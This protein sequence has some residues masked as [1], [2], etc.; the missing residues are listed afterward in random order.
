[1]GDRV[2]LS[3]S[4]DRADLLAVTSTTD[5]WA[6]VCI[7]NTSNE[8]I[9]SFMAQGTQF[10]IYDD[11]QNEWAI[12]CNEDLGVELYHNGVQKL[13]TTATG[14][15]IN[16]GYFNFG[17]YTGEA[18]V[19]RSKATLQ[20]TNGPTENLNPPRLQFQQ[21]DDGGAG[22]TLGQISFWSDELT[23]PRE[24]VLINTVLAS[25]SSGGGD[26]SIYTRT[27]GGA[28]P[29]IKFKIDDEGYF[30]FNKFNTS[31]NTVGMT[32][33]SPTD[34][35]SIVTDGNN[36]II[37]NRRLNDGILVSIRQN[38]TQEG[39]ISVAGT[40]VS[41][42]GFTGTHWSR[43]EDNSR[44]T[45]L[46][47]GTLLESVDEMMDWYQIEY[48][49]P[50]LNKDTGEY[51]MIPFK[52]SYFI[53]EGENIGDTVIY[54]HKTDNRDDNGDYIY[55]EV[56][57]TIIKEGDIKHTKC[58]ISDT[59]EAKNVYG[60]FVAWDDDDHLYEDMLVAQVGTYII[61]IHGSQ[62]VSKGDLIQSNGD[63]TGKVQS[64]DTI[65][66][67]TVAKVISTN[68][69]E[70]YEDNSYTVPCTIHC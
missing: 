58:K 5:T 53:K 13:T 55:E 29:G 49:Y 67:S 36:P 47:K 15:S 21:N 27:A 33:S 8:V 46:L 62:T 40:T 54:S 24:E 3:E 4:A 41:Y 56:E 20:I 61:R 10:G 32:F 51:E 43:L 34:I 2:T 52:E 59:V 38:G 42:N 12:L 14:V 26:F 48:E 6:G 23:V 9:T 11:Q 35:L 16:D 18:N 25:N 65:R 66:A 19:A 17:V 28:N 30:Y 22:Q 45:T 37:I 31:I 68:K 69:V 50:T 44:P 57:A 64:D 7:K 60:L 39:T 1:M 63:G 70:I